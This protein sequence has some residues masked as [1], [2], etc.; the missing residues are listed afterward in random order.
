MS[1]TLYICLICGGQWKEE[2]KDGKTTVTII[3]TEHITCRKKFNAQNDTHIKE[4]R[5]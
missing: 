2:T 4:Q 5:Q 1:R 3:K